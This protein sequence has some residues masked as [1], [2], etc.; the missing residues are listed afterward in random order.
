MTIEA[1]VEFVTSDVAPDTWDETGGPGT[2]HVLP[3]EF[4]LVN[5]TATVHEEL[6]MRLAHLREAAKTGENEAA[7]LPGGGRPDVGPQQTLHR[8]VYHIGELS[9]VDVVEINGGGF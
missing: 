4:L 6:A 5:Q 9:A 1:L 7:G 2:I 3:R 8:A